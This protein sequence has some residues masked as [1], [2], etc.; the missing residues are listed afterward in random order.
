LLAVAEVVA[1]LGVIHQTQD[2]TQAREAEP[3]AV[4]LTQQAF[5]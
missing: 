1:V 4:M 2:T 5:L 3:Q